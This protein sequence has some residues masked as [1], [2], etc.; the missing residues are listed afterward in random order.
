MCHFRSW[1]R[2]RG[3]AVF[4]LF[5]LQELQR[6]EFRNLRLDEQAPQ[7]PLRSAFEDLADYAFHPAGDSPARFVQTKRIVA[8]NRRK[9]RLEEGRMPLG[10]GSEVFSLQ[11]YLHHIGRAALAEHVGRPPLRRKHDVV[12]PCPGVHGLG[13]AAWSGVDFAL[14]AEA[15]TDGWSP[16][17]MVQII[18]TSPSADRTPFQ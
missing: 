4:V 3:Q 13:E 18:V 16:P 8:R 5:V 7:R 2:N 1:S 9:V 12:V 17:L 15:Q 14:E 11:V 10:D 6:E